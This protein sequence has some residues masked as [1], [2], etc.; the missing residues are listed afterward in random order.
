VGFIAVGRVA[1]EQRREEAARRAGD[2][3][4]HR[5]GD[6]SLV[7]QGLVRFAEEAR[8]FRGLPAALP[9]GPSLLRVNERVFLAL[10][11]VHLL[12]PRESGGR[13]VAGVLLPGPV[14]PVS[15]DVG[16][17]VVT[18]RRAVLDGSLERREWP[19]RSI[20]AV[21][22][23]PDSPWSAVVVSERPEPSGFFYGHTDVP[24][25]RF[26]LTLALALYCGAVTGLRA[27]LERALAE[28]LGKK[29]PFP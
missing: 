16:T 5:Y 17:L 9:S 29:P 14:Q 2:D 13:V 12:E 4:A 1:A 3:A 19:F 25:V 26:R 21:H 28:H 7:H 23:D 10:S 24:L 18:D 20:S 27:E 22:H 15:V 8:S 11:G 6:W